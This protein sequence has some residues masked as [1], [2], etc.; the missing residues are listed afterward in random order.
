MIQQ[1]N[2]DDDVNEQRYLF[3]ATNKIIT[4]FKQVREVLNSN[5]THFKSFNNI[6]TAF[7]YMVNSPGWAATDT[8]ANTIG[9]SSNIPSG[10]GSQYERIEKFQQM[11]AQHE[12]EVIKEDEETAK[13]FE[14]NK[15]IKDVLKQM[16]SDLKVMKKKIFRRFPKLQK[17]QNYAN[18]CSNKNCENSLRDRRHVRN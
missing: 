15:E 18:G 13:R 17:R 5:A 7:Q 12:K 6:T 8:F 9:K 14:F 16:L 4:L 1:Q 10:L 3:N 2:I 11:K